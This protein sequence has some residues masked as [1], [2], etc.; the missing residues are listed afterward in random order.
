MN[1]HKNLTSAVLASV[2]FTLATL[3]ALG[4][5][6]VISFFG[7]NGQ[8][9]C[10]NLQAGSTASVEWASSPLG[11]WTNSWKG[12]E[13]VTADSNGVIAVRVPMFYRV[14]G[15]SAGPAGMVLIPSG[16]FTMGD[17]FYEGYEWPSELPTHTVQVSAFYMDTYEVTKALWDEV[18]T[19]AVAH[20]YAFDNEGLGKAANHPVQSVYW[21]DVVKWCN[22]RSEKEGRV[23]AYY[24]DAA[25]TLVYRTGQVNVANNWV[26]WNGGYRLPTEAEWEKAARGGTSGHR[27]PWSDVDTITLNQANYLSYWSGSQVQYAY[28]LPP[29]AGSVSNYNDGVVPYTSPVGSFAPNAYGLYDMAG[30]VNEWCWD[31]WDWNGVGDYSSAAQTNPRGSASGSYRLARG[32]SWGWGNNAK[33]CRVAARGAV[34]YPHEMFPNLGFRVVLAPIQP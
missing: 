23:P 6:P 29:A 3:S 27:F 13:A 18:K 30:N 4:Q 20:G 15:G 5:S 12:L 2:G 32:G 19:W 10:T 34:V 28:D 14:R 11:P 8:L 33:G 1:P 7:G 22:A 24:T 25:Q 9:V 26:K 16:P 21:Y 31:R 17:T